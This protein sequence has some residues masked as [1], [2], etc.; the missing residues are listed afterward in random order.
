ME[1]EID[2]A[3][4]KKIRGRGGVGRE[5]ERDERHSGKDQD[6]SWDCWQFSKRIPI[7]TTATQRDVEVADR[8][9]GRSQPRLT[10]GRTNILHHHIYF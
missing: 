4:R 3:K 1:R 9:P 8:C 2:K 10:S 7:L 6:L 5:R